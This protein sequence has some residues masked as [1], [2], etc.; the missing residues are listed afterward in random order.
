LPGQISRG[1]PE[2][3]PL[4]VLSAEYGAQDKWVDVTEPLKQRIQGNKLTVSRFNDLAGDPIDGVVKELKVK[5]RVGDQTR[6]TT[7]REGETLEL[8]IDLSSGAT[9]AGA[10][11]E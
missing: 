9:P 2:G 10:A 4:E 8:D 5:Y 11:A 6:V 3:A 1:V 7:V